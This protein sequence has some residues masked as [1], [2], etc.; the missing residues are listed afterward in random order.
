LLFKKIF[1]VK[2]TVFLNILK[3]GVPTAGENLSYTFGQILVSRM[4][5]G[6]GT[7]ALAA[8][9]LVITLSRYIFIPGL[10]IG[11]GTQI[12]VGYYVGAKKADKAQQKVYHYFMAGFIISF[13]LI[14]LLNLF[15]KNII[16]LFTQNN[17]IVLIASSVLLVCIFME[18]GRN[19]NTIIIPALK[20][21]GDVRSPVFI[22]MIL[23]WCIGVDGAYLLGV[24][25]N[26]GLVGIWIAIGSDEWINNKHYVQI[27]IN[28]A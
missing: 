16:G 5:A 10:S 24:F 2:K 11:T 1:K 4:I 6:M 19:F 15:K 21:A 22:G 28:N 25:L 23:S 17:E 14:L 8:Y 20:S 3:V 27:F 18:P 9:S 12:K 13:I 26:F 7:S